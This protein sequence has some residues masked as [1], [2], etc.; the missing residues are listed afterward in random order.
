[1][2]GGVSDSPP[3]LPELPAIND[4]SALP[5]ELPGRVSE[6]RTKAWR[7]WV[8]LLILLPYP[9][10]IGL[11][12]AGGREKGTAALSG[13]WQ[14]LLVTCALELAIFGV[15]VGVALWFSKANRDDLRLR[16]PQ[17]WLGV[18]LGF[19]YSVGLRL[20]VG[21]V[22]VLTG[23]VLILTKVVPADQLQ[24]FVMKNRPNVESVVSVSALT[25]D[26]AYFWLTLTLV[27]FVVAGLREEL[28][29]AGSLA[30]LG[31]VAPRLFGSRGGQIL[32]VV[33][34]SL[35]FGM[36]H[37]PQGMLAV[38]MTTVLGLML[39]GIMLLHR[40]TWVAVIAHG[41]FD[42]TSFALI[43]YALEAVK[44]FPK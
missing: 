25:D 22:V 14:G 43:P 41:A 2:A 16:F 36:G 39:G 30:A 20:A 38:G 13:G 5:P 29:R 26:P 6:G 44:Q 35:V 17:P 9:L 3:P 37:L 24:S 32:A 10:L 34:T 40:S 8:H 21:V 23:G 4:R 42:A 31:K 11:L 1:M 18:L 15:I 27:S 12:A 7:W 19:A 33:L 28:W